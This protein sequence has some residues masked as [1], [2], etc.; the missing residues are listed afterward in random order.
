MLCVRF[1]LDPFRG[2]ALLLQDMQTA[3][4]QVMWGMARLP[5]RLGSGALCHFV[6]LLA[7]RDRFFALPGPVHI[8]NQLASVAADWAS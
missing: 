1:Q 8:K 7:V 3:S 2:S 4:L 6:G 5:E